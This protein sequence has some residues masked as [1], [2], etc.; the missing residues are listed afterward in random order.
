M[1]ENKE[2]DLNRIMQLTQEIE[3]LS[4][5]SSLATLD[6]K[7]KK[8]HEL[9]LM[10]FDQYIDDINP[11]EM[12]RLQVIQQQTASMLNVMQDKKKEMGAQIIN[13]KQTNNRMR[14]YTTIAKQK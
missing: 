14:L 6:H 7:V 11:D 12:N 9:L 2:Q 4:D 3:A 5:G 10:F 8:R 1:M 13:G